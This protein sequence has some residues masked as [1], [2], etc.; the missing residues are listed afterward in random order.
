MAFWYSFGLFQTFAA[1]V[2]D[3][4]TAAIASTI[5]VFGTIFGIDFGTAGAGS[6]TAAMASTI[7]VCSV[8]A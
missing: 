7:I 5:I 4:R 8:I 1:T 3:M 6:I 2:L